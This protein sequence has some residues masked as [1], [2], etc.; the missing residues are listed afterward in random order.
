MEATKVESRRVQWQ[1]LTEGVQVWAP[2]GQHGWRA[3]TVVGCA[4]G[5]RDRE[6][7][8]RVAGELFWRKAE[9]KGRN[10]KS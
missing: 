3:G 8:R 7:G 9:L 1:M 10:K 6:Q 5:V 2:F 4:P